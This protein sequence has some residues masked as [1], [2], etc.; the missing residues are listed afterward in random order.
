MNEYDAEIFKCNSNSWNIKSIHHWVNLKKDE[1]ADII[2]KSSTKLKNDPGDEESLLNRGLANS[3]SGNK[4]NAIEDFSKLI[5]QN[6]EY[7][8]AYYYRGYTYKQFQTYIHAEKALKDLDKVIELDNNFY[9]AYLLRGNVY[10]DLKDYDKGIEDLTKAIN[11]NHEN[12]YIYINRGMVY[13]VLK[14][15]DKAL[16]DYT[17]AIEISPELNEAYHHRGDVYVELGEYQK[18]IQ[19][20]YTDIELE[21]KY[22]K[23]NWIDWSYVVT[24]N[25][26]ITYFIRCGDMKN[27]PMLYTE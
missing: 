12:D 20:Y 22:S 24:I 14:D 9:S 18:A 15:Y 17:K 11:L 13:E 2:E 25:K 26:K 21:L 1:L 6:P 5:Q 8:V 23:E 27:L 16:K 7:T 10:I 3:F 4:Q 19:D